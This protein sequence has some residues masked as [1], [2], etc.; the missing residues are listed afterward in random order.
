VNLITLDA[1][2]GAKVQIKIHKGEEKYRSL[3]FNYLNNEYHPILY[4]II[5]AN[6]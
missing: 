6:I 1:K 4:C 5:I 2:S 3:V